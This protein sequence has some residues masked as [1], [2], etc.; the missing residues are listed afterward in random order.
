MI[1][2]QCFMQMERKLSQREYD[3]ID[4]YSDSENLLIG[5]KEKSQK[6]LLNILKHN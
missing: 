4:L 6:I 5:Q 1:E 3:N 2:K